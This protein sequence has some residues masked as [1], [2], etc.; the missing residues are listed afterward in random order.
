MPRPDIQAYSVQRE[1]PFL[2]HFT[3]LNNLASILRHGLLPVSD[4]GGL[5]HAPVINDQLR[6]DGHLD[7]TPLSIAFPN[8]L[9][10]NR[11][12]LLPDTE[13]V[14]LGID[15]S[16]LWTKDCAF[17]QRNAATGM[18]AQ[19]PLDTLRTLAAFQGMYEEIE[20]L[21]SRQEQRLRAYDPTDPQAEVLVFD[22]IEPNLILGVA[23]TTQAI[24][25]DNAG[26]CSNRELLIEGARGGFFATRT[27]VR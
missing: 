15:A 21:N 19:Q 20:D 3:R 13:W 10:F 1:I 2:V 11:Y 12:K 16:V 17:C 4:Q 27:Y 14:V 8:Y 22:Q 5:V 7:G 23:F 18:M 25:D 26:L 24:R 9:M 6:L